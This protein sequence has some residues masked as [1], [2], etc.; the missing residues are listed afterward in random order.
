MA[1]AEEKE[2]RKTCSERNQPGC[3]QTE[4]EVRPTEAGTLLEQEHIEGH[5][6]DQEIDQQRRTDCARERLGEKID[7]EVTTSAEMLE[8]EVP[9]NC[10]PENR[11]GQI[12]P[13]T[14]G[15]ETLPF[16]EEPARDSPQGFDI[17][18]IPGP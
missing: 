14:R 8:I 7:E 17:I 2:Q 15:H 12:D 10:C 9:G 18:P 11:E 5:E 1:F 4:Q 6:R 16:F 3:G 13:F